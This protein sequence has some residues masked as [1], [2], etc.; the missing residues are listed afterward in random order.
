LRERTEVIAG[1][2]RIEEA[3]MLAELLG[4]AGIDVMIEGAIAGALG[5]ALPGAGGGARLRVR[6]EDAARAR[7]AVARSGVFAGG[8]V[9]PGHEIPDEEWAAPIRPETEA[10]E[11]AAG[12][13]AAR[14]WGLFV[15]L[16]LLVVAGLGV[17]ARLVFAARR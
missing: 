17:V 6:A 12:E 9:G 2:L 13:R 4:H 7:E 8:E 1:F 5:A 15:P 16:L 14:T 10:G 3:D 11:P